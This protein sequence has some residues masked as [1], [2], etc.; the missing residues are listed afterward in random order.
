MSV[1]AVKAVLD[2]LEAR[3]AVKLVLVALAEYAD[4]DGASVFPSVATLA[5]RTGFHER[6][7]R[8]VMAGLRESGLIVDVGGSPYSHR[9]RCYRIA[10]ER[11]GSPGRPDRRAGLTVE[12]GGDATQSPPGLTVEQA[13]P[14][15]RAGH[16]PVE[17]PVEPPVNLAPAGASDDPLEAAVLDACGWDGGSLTGK[18]RGW[19]NGSLSDLRKLGATPDEV[20]WKARIYRAN[21]PAG[22]RPTPSALVKHWPAL[23]AASLE[24]IDRKQ[25]DRELAQQQSEQQLRQAL[26]GGL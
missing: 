23:T 15:R 25:L 14:D 17:P 10:L 1:E 20:R 7:V 8:R 3:P 26:G 6:Q 21:D 5:R 16:P 11:F 13:P 4:R 12:Q 19:L 2:G 18:S 24:R 22:K 9:P